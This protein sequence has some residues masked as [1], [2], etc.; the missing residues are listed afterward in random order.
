VGFNLRVDIVAVVLKK[1]YVDHYT[2]GNVKICKLALLWRS[3]GG[4][5]VANKKQCT[6][7]LHH[8]QDTVILFFICPSSASRTSMCI[9]KMGD[10]RKLDNATGKWDLQKANLHMYKFAMTGEFLPGQLD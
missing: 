1:P 5:H 3:F 10:K 6:T 2:D 4:K 8:F 9:P 7:F